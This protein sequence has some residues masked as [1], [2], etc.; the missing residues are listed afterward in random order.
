M[1]NIHIFK[2][3]SNYTSSLS[4][5]PKYLLN[6]FRNPFKHSFHRLLSMSCNLN[7]ASFAALYGDRAPR[8]LLAQLFSS[9]LYN[10]S[11]PQIKNRIVNFH[12]TGAVVVF[13]STW[14]HSLHNQGIQPRVQVSVCRDPISYTSANFTAQLGRA[15]GGMPTFFSLSSS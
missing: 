3:H 15:S 10:P 11:L 12:R 2:N 8:A 7:K 14:M 5:F 9:R 1:T 6:L 4:N 13:P